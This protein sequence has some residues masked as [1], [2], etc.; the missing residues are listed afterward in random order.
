IAA[1]I[2]GA[3][4]VVLDVPGHL[5]MIADPERIVAQVRAALA[6]EHEQDHEPA[7]APA[8]EPTGSPTEG[9]ATE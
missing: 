4:L 6:G 9:D 5:P 1:A 8:Q 2:P 7:S 3:R